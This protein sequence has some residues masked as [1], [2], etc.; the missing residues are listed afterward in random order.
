LGAAANQDRLQPS[1]RGIALSL[2]HSDDC[3]LLLAQVIGT[4]T[5]ASSQPPPICTVC[6]SHRRAAHDSTM[7]EAAE[8]DQDDDRLLTEHHVTLL[9]AHLLNETPSSRDG[10]ERDEE[11][12]HRRWGC[13]LAQEAGILLKL[14]QQ[15]MCTA[16]NL[17]HRF[18]YCKSLKAY[19]TLLVAMGC[20]FLASK[21]EEKPKR[22]REV[23][24]AFH[25]VY[26]LRTKSEGKM[27]LGGPMYAGW[28]HSLVDIERIILKELGFSFYIIEHAHRFILFY[29]K[30]LDGDGDM[31][32][33]AW[34]Y[35]NDSLRTD[36]QLRVKSEVIACAAISLAAMKL[37]KHLPTQ[38]RDGVDWFNAFGVDGKELEA[39]AAE[40]LALYDAEAPIAWLPSLAPG[41]RL[42]APEFAAS[43][44]KKQ[45]AR[46]AEHKAKA[47]ALEAAKAEAAALAA[48]APPPIVEAERS[49]S[50][51][52]G[53]RRRDRSRSKD[54]HRSRRDRRDR[55][56]SRD[57]TRGRRR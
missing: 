38:S 45:E 7:A 16:Q 5:T 15:V 41:P 35:C 9:P 26:K 2:H 18:Y 46:E 14:P 37:G 39:A 17:I 32:Q 11:F 8:L 3:A 25:Y 33:E 44:L 55:S 52:R 53:R 36:A 21:V 20:L 30:L 24:F 6:A 56:R 23:L 43:V 29:V 12:K 49:R 10:V 50:R 31:A 13:E 47:E 54:R 51:D 40:I 34:A 57:R 19:D 42:T 4:R 27:E 22:L 28:K 48:A 1:V